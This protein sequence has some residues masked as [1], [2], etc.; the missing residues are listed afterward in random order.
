MKTIAIATKFNAISQVTKLPECITFLLLLAN[1]R[2]SDKH[3][4][5]VLAAAA[6]NDP[7]IGAHATNDAFLQAVSINSVSAVVKQCDSVNQNRIYKS[8]LRS[9]NSA[10]TQRNG[11]NNNR[12]FKNREPFKEL[13]QQEKILLCDVPNV[14]NA[15][16]TDISNVITRL[17]EH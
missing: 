11:Y 15:A 12:I 6:L 4:I 5:T 8:K 9:A 16:K 13:S 3:R 17:M 14:M 2:V 1:A 10:N 7:N